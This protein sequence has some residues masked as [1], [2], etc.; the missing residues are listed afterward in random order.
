MDFCHL[1]APRRHLDRAGPLVVPR[2]LRDEL[3]V[4]PGQPLLAGVRDGRLEIEPQPVAADLVE[5]DG[6]LVITPREP[7]PPLTRAAVRELLDDLR[8]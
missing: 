1:Y 3:A 6:V 8:R 2:A 7:V 4:E 5:R